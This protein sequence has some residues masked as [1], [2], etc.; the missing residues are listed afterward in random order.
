MHAVT[1]HLCVPCNQNPLFYCDAMLHGQIYARICGGTSAILIAAAITPDYDFFNVWVGPSDRLKVFALGVQRLCPDLYF[2]PWHQSIHH[3][4]LFLVW[5]EYSI[6]VFKTLFY[7]LFIEQYFCSL[8]AFRKYVSLTTR[9]PLSPAAFWYSLWRPLRT[10]P[11]SR[12]I[13]SW[14]EGTWRQ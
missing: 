1:L 3:T 2:L 11:G 13:L 7:Y 9:A 10:V 5:T 14:L 6:E 8:D 4:G 12:N